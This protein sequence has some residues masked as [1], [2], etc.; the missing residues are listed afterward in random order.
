MLFTNRLFGLA[1]FTLGALAR[2][3]SEKRAVA[4]VYSSCTQP[5]TV[6]LTFDDGPYNYLTDISDTLA[7]AGAKGTFFFNGNN[8][9]CIYDLADSVTYAYN[10]GHQIASHT[11]AHKHLND[12]SYDQIHSEMWRVEQALEKII[13]VTPAF[14]RPPYG[15]YN[16]K[17][18]NVAGERGQDLVIWDFDSQDSVGATASQSKKYYDQAIAQHPNN[19]LALNHEVYETTAHNVLPYAI[20]KLQAAGYQLVTVAE[21]LGK[22]PYQSVG[23]PTPRDS[24]WTCS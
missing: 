2:P 14:V 15:E 24:S 5:N 4:Q 20:Q 12:L 11:W 21:C 19:I 13:G 23:S 9:A 1:A 17:S 8:W 18:R 7:N 3:A 6:A 22:Q 10:H 16:G